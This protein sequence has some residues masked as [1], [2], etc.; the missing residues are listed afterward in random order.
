MSQLDTYYRAF[1]DYR[2]I[3]AGQKDCIRQR[4]NIEKADPENDLIEVV[5]TNC[6]IKDDWIDAIEKGLIPLEKALKEERQFIRTNG[7]IV[8]I[9]KVKNVSR[10][11]VEHLARHSNL[12]SRKPEGEDIIPDELYTVERLTDYSVYENRFLYMLLCYLRDFISYRY[13]KILDLTNTY[14]GKMVMKKTVLTQTGKTVFAIDLEEKHK[15]D[16]YLKLHNPAKNQ[17]DRI[18]LLLKT[19]MLYLSTPLM[20]LVSQAPLLK[21]PIT[22]TNVLKMDFN[23]KG[24]MELYYY[25][26]AYEGDGFTIEQ[27]VKKISPFVETVSDEFAEIVTLS[28]FL[29]YQYGLDISDDLKASYAKQEKERELKEAQAHIEQ[30]ERLKKRIK[31]SG[32]SPEEYML[33]LEQRNRK[34]E[35]ASVQLIAAQEQ[36]SEL[37]GQVEDLTQKNNDLSQTIADQKQQMLEMEADFKNQ[38]ADLTTEYENKITAIKEQHAE[39]VK[40]INE[41]HFEEINHINE[42]HKEEVNRL[43]EEHA[44]EV[45]SLNEQHSEEISRINAEHEENIAKLNSEHELSMQ[46]AEEGFRNERNSLNEEITSLKDTITSKDN[47]KQDMLNQLDEVNKKL[48]NAENQKV[49][50]MAQVNSLKQEQGHFKGDEFSSEENFEEIERQ[51]QV[52]KDFFNTQW[53]SAKKRIRKEVLGSAKVQSDKEN[54]KSD[55]GKKSQ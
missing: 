36:I 25:V 29:T 47:E 11:S 32:E 31:E 17:L 55:K 28:Q 7:E 42:Q 15:N 1:L 6:I 43:N 54:K 5:K 52:F 41:Q 22:E 46:Q 37:N 9:E 13:D 48:D 33:M 30:I 3:T 39:E 51:Y 16:D 18:D 27:E 50:F 49:L 20:K 34:L 35:N 40:R 10:D 53:K 12:I 24:A 38:I 23:F 45:Q 44:E 14:D 2:K 26:V 4:K 8:P 19:V 21:P